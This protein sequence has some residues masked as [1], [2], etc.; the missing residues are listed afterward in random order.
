MAVNDNVKVSVEA[1]EN[2]I[3]TFNTKKETFLS[4]FDKIKLTVFDLGGTWTGDASNAF[5]SQVRELT[6]KLKTIETSMEGAVS[7]LQTVITE[8]QRVESENVSGS[9]ALADDASVTYI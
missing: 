2:A 8:Y 5:E 7:K 1:L 3:S 4:T 9:D 6:T